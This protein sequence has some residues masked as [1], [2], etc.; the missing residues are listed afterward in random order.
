MIF[1]FTGTGNSLYAANAIAE[2]QGE[3][4]ISIPAEMDRKQEVYSYEQKDGELL[5][6]VFPVYAWGPPAIVLDFVS[7]L[8]V[9]GKPYVFSLCT[10][11]DEE[12]QST[13]M[14]AKNLAASG[15]VLKSSFALR[16]PNN[17]VVGFDVDS[18]DLE[19]RKLKEAEETLREING[20]ISRRESAHRNI[21]GRFP[22]LKTRVVN[23]LFNRFAMDTKKFYAD[24]KCISCGLCEKVCPVHTIKVETK[25]VWGKACTQ[26]LACIHRCPVRAIQMGKGTE[27]KGRYL[28]PDLKRLEKQH[29]L[30]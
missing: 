16:M 19:E 27:Q 3:Q 20:I 17:Y 13:R 6:F 24:D 26:C 28:H 14:L 9:T 25:P 2:A 12:G 7:K 10:C 18:K 30:K 5:G 29:T 1:Y 23:P 11:G 21:P 4:L 22:R 8:R 15:I